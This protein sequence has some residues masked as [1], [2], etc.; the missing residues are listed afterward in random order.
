M[1]QR[2]RRPPLS[3][4]HTKAPWPPQ[5]GVEHER[6]K[7]LRPVRHVV[8]GAVERIADRWTIITV[9]AALKEPGDAQKG[10]VVMNGVPAAAPTAAMNLEG[11]E[12]VSQS[13]CQPL[14]ATRNVGLGVG[15]QLNR[16]SAASLSCL[17]TLLGRRRCVC[18]PVTTHQ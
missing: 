5:S 4:D 11:H 1:P 12:A 17:P 2:D 13:G 10:R 18:E 3:Y 16:E 8:G 6:L 15:E 9:G 7:G 14:E